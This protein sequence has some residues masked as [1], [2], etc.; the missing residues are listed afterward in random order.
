MSVLYVKPL[1]AR[2]H[3]QVQY[4]RLLR[5][6]LHFTHYSGRAYTVCAYSRL[7]SCSILLLFVL[8]NTYYILST[9]TGFCVRLTAVELCTRT[10]IYHARVYTHDTTM[11]CVC[12]TYTF[13]ETVAKLSSSDGAR[14]RSKFCEVSSREGYPRYEDGR[15]RSFARG[16]VHVY[17][18]WLCIVRSLARRRRRRHARKRENGKDNGP[19][20]NRLNDG[21]H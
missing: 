9:M 13:S 10:R 19:E 3:R 8:H 21:L 15:R 16:I 12:Y 11:M 7:C 1:R 14:A 4:K 17:A 2:I 18:I 5:T 20:L 6:I